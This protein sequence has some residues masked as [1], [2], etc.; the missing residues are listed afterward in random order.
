MIKYLKK[1]FFFYFL[2]SLVFSLFL[3][4]FI[5][6]SF[7]IVNMWSFSQSHINYFEGFTKRGL[8]GTILITIEYLTG[9]T[10][11]KIFFI[12]FILLT[13]LNIL[14]FFLNIKKYSSNKILLIFLALNPTLIM[15]SFNDLGGYQRFD[16]I[17]IS[18]ILYH[19][20]LANNFYNNKINIK[21]YQK[22]ITFFI[23]PLIAITSFIHEIIFW[24]LP[25]HFLTTYNISND[26]KKTLFKYLFFLI[27]I[28]LTF[29]YPVSEITINDMVANL[30]NRELWIDAIIIAS[31]TNGNINILMQEINNNLL[32]AYNFKINLFFILMSIIPYYIIFIFL[33]KNSIIKTNTNY[34][35]LFLIIFPYISLFAIGDTG[36]WINLISFTSFCFLAQ[37][38]LKKRI[39][40]YSFEPKNFEKL[41]LQSIFFIFLLIFLFFTRVP[42]CCNLEERKL[43]IWGGISDKVLA[44]IKIMTGNKDDFY[45]IN[46]RF[47]E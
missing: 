32:N 19:C 27:P 42:H 47:R 5:L 17:S 43:T 3:S 26:Y 13:T 38:P 34:N 10:T 11:K 4:V 33:Y 44:S 39:K 18:L 30:Q 7:K 22:R 29:F 12:F 1:N 25:F 2:L 35:Y 36:R 16:S 28:S 23:L 8:F 24:S 9:I 40:N 37:F 21:T 6:S 41:L 15:F 31:S 46:K 45:N 20:L 14:L